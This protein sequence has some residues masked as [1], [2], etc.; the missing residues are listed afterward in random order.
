MKSIGTWR[1]AV[2][3]A[4]A[5]LVGLLAVAPPALSQGLPIRVEGL[6]ANVAALQV[7]QMGV[8]EVVNCDAGGSIAAAVANHAD[9]LGRLEVLFSGTCNESVVIDRSNVSLL[10]QGGATLQAPTTA[11]FAIMVL[12]NVRNVTIG[13]LTVIGAS[14]GGIAVNQGAHAIVRNATIHSAGSGAMALDNGVLNVTAST[15]RNNVQ[16]VYAARGGVV[17]VSNSTISNNQIG[18]IAFKAGNIILTSSNPDLASGS[19]GPVV[20]NNTTG[21]LARSGGFIELADTTIENNTGNG[22]VADTGG[23]VHLFSRLWATATG[24]RI[25]GNVGAGLLLNKNSNFVASDGSNSITANGRG[26]QCHPST[27][28]VAPP[29]FVPNVTGNSFG[30]IL[31]CIP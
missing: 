13:D 26:I 11:V 20:R 7:V 3:V 8:Q 1:K 21:A 2:G 30:D 19:Q 12:G 15:V 14:T 6:E 22:I 4:A 23:T 18:A 28:Y 27:G 10:G 9:G 25:S 29:A 17:N 5:P 16:G 24:N 31:N